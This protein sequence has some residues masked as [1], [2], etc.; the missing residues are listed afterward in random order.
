M[1]IDGAEVKR[2]LDANGIKVNGVL[3][4]GAHE[5]EELPFYHSLGLSSEAVYWI[6]ALPNKVAENIHRG[7]PNVFQSVMSDTDGTLVKFNV[8][9][10]VQSSSFLEMGSHL[11][12]HPHVKN[13]V[14]VP[15]V[16]TTIDTF[17]S[18]HRIP[19]KTLDF[20]NFD[21]QGAELKALH[22]AKEALPHAKAL[23][24][25]VNT[26]EVYKG[27]GLL[28]D[29]DAFLTP[30]GFTRVVTKMTEAGWGDALYLKVSSQ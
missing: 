19:I 28:P 24:L 29:L 26:E 14:S 3:H 22:G 16:T 30:H 6:E 9:N 17:V 27:C 8:T 13:V 7:I 12:H 4:I 11:H 20:W 25:E 15:M 23:Y 2:L 18:T 1:L 5:C 10:N 21:I